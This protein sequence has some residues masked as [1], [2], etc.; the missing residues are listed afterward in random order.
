[1]DVELL[2]DLK[3]SKQ[4]ISYSTFTSSSASEFNEEQRRELALLFLVLSYIYMK[5]GE[6]TERE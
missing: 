5:G 4:Y 1:M 6:I 3:S 2:T